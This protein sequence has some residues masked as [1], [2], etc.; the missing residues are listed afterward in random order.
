MK[1]KW[2]RG[3]V[4]RVRLEVDAQSDMAWVVV[5]DALPAGSTALGRGL[6]GDSALATQGEGDALELLVHH[7]TGLVV[8]AAL[9]Q[10]VDAH[11]GGRLEVR[12]D[13]ELLAV[14]VVGLARRDHLPRLEPSLRDLV[15]VDA[16]EAVLQVLV[17]GGG[18]DAHRVGVG[19]AVIAH[20]S[21]SRVDV[22]VR[23]NGST[24]VSVIDSVP[25][26]RRTTVC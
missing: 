3:D 16:R 4:A 8:A 15:P 13:V 5:D 17:E 7:L 14:L 23:S 9:P 6:G 21:P 12:A 22:L 2:T 19:E 10:D 25:S 20:D 24:G 26:G 11:P 1:D 18:H